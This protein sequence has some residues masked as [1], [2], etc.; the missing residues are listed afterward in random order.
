MSWITSGNSSTGDQKPRCVGRDP[1]R[2]IAFAGAVL[3]ILLAS[4]G[5][6]DPILFPAA[7][8]G[9]PEVPPGL[10]T[11]AVVGHPL[12]ELPGVRVTDANG[13]PAPGVEVEFRVEAGGGMVSPE[14]VV[15]DVEGWARP[16]EWVLGEEAGT[17]VLMADLGALGEERFEVEGVV[18]TVEAVHL[19]QASQD[20]SGTVGGVAERPGLLRVVVSAEGPNQ[21]ALDVRVRLSV[22]GEV[23]REETIPAPTDSV[24]TEPDLAHEDDTWNLAL[25]ASDVREGL[26][27]EVV[28]DPDSTLV[29][30]GREDLRFPRGEGTASLDVRPI[31]PLNLEL[32]PIHWEARDITGDIHSGNLGTYLE[33]TERWLPTSEISAN[34]RDPFSTDEDLGTSSGWMTLLSDLQA[35]RTAEAAGDTYY[36]GIIPDFQGIS[37][38]G[39]A[40]VASS[41]ASRFRTALSYDRLPVAPGTVAHE[42]AHNMGQLHAPCGSPAGVDSNFPYSDGG[43]GVP[44]YDVLDGELV[45]P[46]GHSDFLSYCHPRWISDYMYDR[47]VEWRRADELAE[48][49]SL[50]GTGAARAS[51][52]PSA[53]GT[54]GLLVWGRAGPEGVTLNPAFS[55]EAPPSLP[56]EEGPLELRGI[57]AGGAEV[58]R[59]AFQGTYP[60]RPHGTEERHFAFLVPAAAGELASLER[61][62]LSTPWGNAVRTAA[63]VGGRGI[64]AEGMDDPPIHM[65]AV[66]TERVR[67]EWDGL[68]G[69][70]AVMARH[71]ETGRVLG[72]GRAGELSLEARDVTPDQVEVLVSDGLRSRSWER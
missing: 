34:I 68:G 19:N 27:V 28:L 1:A 70:S 13:N 37:F 48:S 30:T 56:E 47:L 52:P 39:L 59:L 71:A 61:I 72:I 57:D 51:A 11:G 41:P 7:T 20:F 54:E 50:A 36:H 44:G 23:F 12:E 62:E 60:S 40:Y 69:P 17:N 3:P 55:L 63:E 18:P 53:D 4:C 25:P 15:T 66:G 21:W 22:D 16:S 14:R 58:F 26:D 2:G 64:Q 38:G 8:E 65:E 49:P 32:I 42:L 29:P 45:D 67:L 24:P 5:D 35:V 6:G 46:D 43:I 10:E 33:E 31:P 9:A